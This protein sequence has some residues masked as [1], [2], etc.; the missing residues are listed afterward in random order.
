VG[1]DRGEQRVFPLSAAPPHHNRHELAG[2]RIFEEAALFASGDMSVRV[3]IPQS[4]LP[5]CG[6]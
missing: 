6:A 1:P 2:R 4:G 3:Y 5:G